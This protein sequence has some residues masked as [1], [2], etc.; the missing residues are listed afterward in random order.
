MLACAC[1]CLHVW[2]R[3][4]LRALRERRSLNCI[5]PDLRKS[6][7]SG[8]NVQTNGRGEFH[9]IHNKMPTSFKSGATSNGRKIIMF[10]EM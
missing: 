7:L 9:R 2:L 8:E 3:V 5:G 4:W 1:A 10:T 6:G